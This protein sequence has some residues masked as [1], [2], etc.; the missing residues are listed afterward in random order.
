MKRVL[1]A[2]GG[3]MIL[4]FGVAAVLYLTS[5]NDAVRGDGWRLVGTSGMA[6]SER[7]RPPAIFSQASLVTDEESLDVTWAN[8]GVDE[9]QPELP[10][11]REAVLRVTGFGSSSC[12]LHF[13]GLDFETLKLVATMSTGFWLGCSGDAVPYTFLLVVER[14]RLPL[15]PFVVDVVVDSGGGPRIE[16]QTVG[17]LTAARW[18]AL[19]SRSH[20]GG[21]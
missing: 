18:P 6:L 10:W 5:V 8:L 13:D 15:V 4:L 14:D 20:L 17:A 3:L 21:V 1:V 16:P 9:P 11:T 2:G 12:P 7:E 19:T